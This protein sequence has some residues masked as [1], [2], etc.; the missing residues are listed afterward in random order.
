MYGYDEE[1][2][3]TF[4][5]NQGQLFDEPVAESMEEAEA[6]LEDCMATVFPDKKALL[7]YIDEEGIDVEGDIT[8]ELEV[9]A[10]PDGRYLYVEA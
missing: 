9:F 10:L 8:E 6:F 4:L 2:L 7:K 5:A 1:C 3:K